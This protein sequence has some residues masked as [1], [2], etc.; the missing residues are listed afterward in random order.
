M[1]GELIKVT[2]K[3]TFRDVR[4]RF[5]KADDRMREQKRLSMRYLGMRWV[6]IAREE[7]PKG[8]TGN[9][10]R[11]IIYRTSEQGNNVIL[12]T[13]AAQPLSTF[14]VRGTKSH[15][16][17]PRL[18]GALY[19]FWPKVGMFVV[20][21]KNPKF[22]THVSDD[23]LWVGKGYVDHPG[24]KPNPYVQRAYARW[25]PEAQPELRRIALKYISVIQG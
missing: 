18:A 22:R 25:K 2:V 6:N 15:Q 3:P 14:I 16:I 21:P 19:F 1:P 13:Y 8:K 17:P 9:F 12:Q 4:G 5:A 23:K 11:S 7:A 20:V 10:A 24:T